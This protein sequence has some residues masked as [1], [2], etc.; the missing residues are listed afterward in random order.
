MFKKVLLAF[1]LT[2]I[3]SAAL[4]QNDAPNFVIFPNV[5]TEYLMSINASQVL[6][7]DNKVINL[8]KQTLKI[9][10][11][12]PYR[13][14][15]IRMIYDAHHQV[16][17]LIVY[18]LS[19]T[20]K[21]FDLVRIDL[22][23]NFTVANVI[24]HYELQDQDLMQTPAYAHKHVPVCPDEKVQF[25]IGNNFYHDESVNKEVLK[26][27][28]MAKNHGYNPV[29][30]NVNDSSTQQPTIEAYENWLS[31][32]NV[33]G[34]YNEAHGWSR[35]IVLS[36][37]DFTYSIIK[38]DLIGK[39]KDKVI[40]FD[41]CETFHN[42]LLASVIDEDKGNA[43]QYVA[44]IISL[45]FGASERTASC[46]WAQAFD[47]GDLHREML[48]A[49]SAKHGLQLDGYGIGGHGDNHL[50]QATVDTTTQEPTTA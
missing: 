12:S 17:S 43:A 44:G 40:L 24:K 11:D 41:S 37:G 9:T 16:K 20:Y 49:C 42:P 6:A 2:A 30:M 7:T 14:I 36:D 3:S 47:H 10:P 29:L 1:A 34:F 35:G 27:F 19:T 32:P 50:L 21:S 33:K 31:C 22:N 15:K 13:N 46:F 48:N 25:V 38:A 28:E 45:P 8:V 23:A 5:N 18:L 26:V 39:F 4:A